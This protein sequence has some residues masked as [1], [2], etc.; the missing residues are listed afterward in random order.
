M[1]QP[2]N[3]FLELSEGQVGEVL[4]IINNY[5]YPLKFVRE[6]A[7]NLKIHVSFSGL[8]LEQLMNVD[9][10]E[11]CRK[12]IDI[13]SLLNEYR[14]TKSIEIVG[15]GYSHPIFP[16]IPEQDWDFQI[17]QGKRIIME[18]FD[19]EPRG[20]WCTLS[21]FHPRLIPI[22]KKYGYEYLILDR[23]DG[24]YL[25]LPSNQ[26]EDSSFF[27]SPWLMAVDGC[28][29]T[30]VSNQRTK[31]GVSE[32]NSSLELSHQ[33]AGQEIK[34][35]HPLTVTWI[36]LDEL[37]DEK[38][39]TS[40]YEFWEENFSDTLEQIIHHHSEIKSILLKDYLRENKTNHL[41]EI[42]SDIPM[43]KNVENLDYLDRAIERL[44]EFSREF[45]EVRSKVIKRGDRTLHQDYLLGLMQKAQQCLFRSEAG[46]YLSSDSSWAARI[47]DNINPGM[48]ILEEMRKKL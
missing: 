48:I 29:M 18:V 17:F 11:A 19:K 30:V 27:E 34:L 22:L 16:F 15:T 13:P 43:S 40:G 36:K 32:T 41:L 21:G 39:D 26:G 25:G 7:G 2:P 46:C 24:E 10:I 45:H 35:Q 33:I 14:E 20:F 44:R 5:N 1:N 37:I 8:L 9:I 4:R 31:V 3:S 28:E 42:T 6:H 23:V 47:Y 38:V 12:I